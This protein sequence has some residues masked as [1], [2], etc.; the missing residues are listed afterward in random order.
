MY[1]CRYILVSPEYLINKIFLQKSRV[2]SDAAKG[3]G[4]LM[5]ELVFTLKCLSGYVDLANGSFGSGTGL[6]KFGSG[7][8]RVK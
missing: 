4:C 7:H 2:S 3:G 8:A 5:D 6:A 1:V